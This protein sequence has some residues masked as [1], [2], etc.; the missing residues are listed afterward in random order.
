MMVSMDRARGVAN[1]L[2]GFEPT[3]AEATS[4]HRRAI[5]EEC[6]V[7]RSAVSLHAVTQGMR[8]GGR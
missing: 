1:A 5:V 4:E 3:R 2:G 8:S 7:L 6:E